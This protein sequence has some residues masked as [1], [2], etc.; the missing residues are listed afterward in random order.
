[1]AAGAAGPEVPVGMRAVAEAGREWSDRLDRLY[2]ELDSEGRG[3][4]NVR[5]AAGP[6]AEMRRE[7]A[8]L[9]GAR[10]AVISDRERLYRG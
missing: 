4:G 2:A 8:A 5:R 7:K 9:E 6:K 1:M 10:D 3:G